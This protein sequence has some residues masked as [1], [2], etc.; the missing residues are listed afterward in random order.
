M[1]ACVSNLSFSEI[2]TGVPD[3]EIRFV[4]GAHGDGYPFDDGGD[5][6]GNVL[7][8]AFFPDYGGDAHF[9]DYESWTHQT[10]SG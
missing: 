8:H 7:A 6:E 9:D 2:S 10:D 1:W 4:T 5:S 3:I